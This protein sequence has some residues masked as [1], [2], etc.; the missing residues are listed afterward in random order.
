MTSTLVTSNNIVVGHTA[1]Q[2]PLFDGTNYQFWNTRIAV[3]I[4]ACDMDMSDLILEGPFILIKKS[5]NEDVVKPKAKWTTN[6]KAKV[7]VN[8]KA[9]NTLQCALNLAKFNR[10]STCKTI[11]A[12]WDTL[13]ITHEETS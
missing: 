10:S 8:F 6:D 5:K 12:I 13:K 11:K 7:Q 4:K 9:I 2:L 3:Y 1:N